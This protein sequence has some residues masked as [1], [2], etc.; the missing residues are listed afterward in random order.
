MKD[1]SLT[2]RTVRSGEH[3]VVDGNCDGTN[4]NHGHGEKSLV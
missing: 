2:S 1:V 3:T 4:G